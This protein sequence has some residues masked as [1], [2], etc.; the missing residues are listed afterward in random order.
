MILTVEVNMFKVGDIFEM[1]YEN[2]EWNTAFKK[3]KFQVIEIKSDCLISKIIFIPANCTEWYVKVGNSEVFPA[4]HYK[5]LKK[6]NN[7]KS[8]LPKWF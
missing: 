5:D 8:H 3:V 6:C 7:G 1:N 4:P 2:R